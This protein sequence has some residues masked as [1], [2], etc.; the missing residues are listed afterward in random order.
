M[1][2]CEHALWSA[3]TIS[4]YHIVLFRFTKNLSPDK[5]HVSTLKGEG[6]LSNLELDEKLLTELLDLP[7]WIKISKAVCNRVAIKVSSDAFLFSCLTIYIGLYCCTD[8]C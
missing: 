4:S 5:I 6:D 2:I 1:Y 8:I 3:Q 7:T